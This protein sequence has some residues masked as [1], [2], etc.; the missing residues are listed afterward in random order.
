MKSERSQ[1]I[2]GKMIYIFEILATP[3]SD[4]LYLVLLSYPFFLILK[5]SSHLNLLFG[6]VPSNE[7]QVHLT[8]T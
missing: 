4:I 2:S 5:S 6:F 1:V 3:V 7:K 8:L